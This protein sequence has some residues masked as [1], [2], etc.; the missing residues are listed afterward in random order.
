MAIEIDGDD[1]FL[2]FFVA[3]RPCVIAVDSTLF[4]SKYQETLIVITAQDGN[5][6][7]FSIAFGVVDFE[8]DASWEWFFLKLRGAIGP[9]ENLLFI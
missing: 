1:H 8:N 2:Y 3:L 9:M 5:G 7:I 6:K 4:K